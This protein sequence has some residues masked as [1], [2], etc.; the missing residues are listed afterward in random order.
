MVVVG[1]GNSGGQAAVHLARYAARVT[2]AA[3]GPSLSTTMSTYLVREI[4]SN[5]RI[6]VRTN[7]DIVDGGG[8]GRLEWVEL[9]DRTTGSARPHPRRRACSS[10]SAPRPAPTGSRPRS[11]ETTAASSS[12][13]TTST[14]PAGRSTRRPHALETSVP[15]VFAAGDVRANNVKRVAAAVGEGSIAVP[16]VHRYLEELRSGR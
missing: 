3:R 11:S 9:A 6:A 7:V 13:A 15:G 12:P 14:A 2:I 8:D 16:M 10:S 5:P 4:E 1:A